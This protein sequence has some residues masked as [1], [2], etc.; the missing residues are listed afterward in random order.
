MVLTFHQPAKTS[1]TSLASPARPHVPLG[2][3]WFVDCAFTWDWEETLRPFIGG[4]DAELGKQR[5]GDADPSME[6]RAGIVVV[7]RAFD[8]SD[9]AFDEGQ[10]DVVA[11]LFGL[12]LP[13]AQAFLEIGILTPAV[14]GA[15]GDARFPGGGDDVFAASDRAKNRH[16][17][18]AQMLGCKIPQLQ[19]RPA[20]RE[21]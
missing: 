8:D 13:G 6:L 16:L 12:G 11:G 7:E 1:I 18:S 9:G 10:H 20:R 21:G 4:E 3:F 17:L 14:D 15:A 2:H 19:R 5:D